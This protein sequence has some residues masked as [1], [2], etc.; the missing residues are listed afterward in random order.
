MEK[1]IKEVLEELKD[2]NLHSTAGRQT[3]VSAIMKEI[4]RKDKGF[5]LELNTLAVNALSDHNDGWTKQYYKDKLAEE[6]ITNQEEGFI[7]ES[8][9]GKTVYRRKFGKYNNREVI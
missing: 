3:I 6:I 9:D 2:T 5:F 1:L 8:P 7:Y 4:R